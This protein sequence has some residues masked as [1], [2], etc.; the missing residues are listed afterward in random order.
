[1]HQRN[2][3]QIS[4]FKERVSDNEERLSAMCQSLT[5]VTK[6]FNML[7]YD[8]DGDYHVNLS[9]K[10]SRL[11]DAIENYSKKFLRLENK[12]D[13][14]MDIEKNIGF[15]TARHTFATL[16]LEATG[17]L[18]TVSKL[19]GH[20]Q[21]STTQVYAKIVDSKKQDAVNLLPNLKFSS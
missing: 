5:N 13:M 14:A 2:N 20:K 12:E 3:E 16:I 8:K 21:I 10:Q 17:D 9:S 1:M 19:L 15:H 11:F 18:Y 6:A 4:S 7:K